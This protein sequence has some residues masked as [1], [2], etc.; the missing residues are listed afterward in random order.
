MDRSPD[1][2]LTVLEENLLFAER[3]V[4]SL[5]EQMATLERVVELL[6]RRLAAIESRM[7]EDRSRA[8]SASE[9]PDAPSGGPRDEVSPRDDP[10]LG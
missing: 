10:T 5:S 3:T 6:G 1:E 4:E 8:A 2:R 9:S 7:E